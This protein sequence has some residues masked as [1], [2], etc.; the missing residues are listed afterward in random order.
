MK[1]VVLVKPVRIPDTAD[2]RLFAPDPAVRRPGPGGR[3]DEPD[4][5]AVEQAKRIACRRLDVQISAVTMGPAGAAGEWWS[6][7]A[8]GRTRWS[9]SRRSDH[10]APR[11]WR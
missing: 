8:G 6:P 11:C 7:S 4:E 2:D 1:I 9:S 3:L 5:C 10:W